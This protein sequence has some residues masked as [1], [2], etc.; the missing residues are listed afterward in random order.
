MK[1]FMHG[2]T[3]MHN[4]ENPLFKGEDRQNGLEEPESVVKF[5]K[6]MMQVMKDKK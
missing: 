6:K 5:A 3:A 4:V 1:V 2:E